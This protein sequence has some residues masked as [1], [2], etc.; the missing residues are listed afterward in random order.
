MKDL[1]LIF[2]QLK[3]NRINF[4]TETFN[5]LNFG[6]YEESYLVDYFCFDDGEFNSLCSSCKN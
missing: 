1:D 4:V 3:E 6:R 2:L 5:N